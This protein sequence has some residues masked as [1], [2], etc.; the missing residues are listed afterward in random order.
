MNRSARLFPS[1]GLLCALVSSAG[2]RAGAQDGTPPGAASEAA[3]R[4]GIYDE[5]ADADA[6][7]AEALAR[8]RREGKRVLVTYGANWCG[9]CHK[10]HEL[11]KSD[12]DLARTLLYEYEQ[13]LVDVGRFDRNMNVAGR[14]GADLKAAGIPYLTVLDAD[15]KPLANQETGSLEEGDHHDPAKVRAFLEKWVAAPRDAQQVYD[16]ALASAAREDKRVFLHFGAPWCGW[17]HR[18]DDFF[19]RSDV[20]A[21]MN[22]DFIDLKI[23]VE[24]M[25]GGKELD[26]RIRGSASGS[27]GIPWFALLDAEGKVLATSD[28]PGPSGPRN[29]G[30]P[31]EPHEIDHF[32][33]V[34]KKT[35]RRI[36]GDD[37]A[38]LRAALEE[39]ARTI[40]AG[41]GG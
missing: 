1:I 22:K 3:A 31:V 28:A 15:G 34:L 27:G 2:S 12:R 30:F 19:A 41:R 29:V 39:N 24:R 20:A 40:K 35:A 23:D 17:C 10:L 26:A 33:D 8:A 9:W 11:L 18:L 13:V 38:A 6:R 37:L 7:I 32:I 5:S 14:Y 21:I 25:K 4:Q 16:G 36:G